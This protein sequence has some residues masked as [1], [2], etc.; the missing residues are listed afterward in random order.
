MFPDEK[1]ARAW[2]EEIRWPNQERYCPHCGS[3]KVSCVPNEKPVSYWC[4]DYRDYFS[5]KTGTIMHRSKVP[6]LIWVIAIYFM[7]TSL[8]GVSSMKLHRDLG[9]FV[10]N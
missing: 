5:V 3:I 9:G 10:Q 1:F 2:F 8:K 7:S 4:S 6:L